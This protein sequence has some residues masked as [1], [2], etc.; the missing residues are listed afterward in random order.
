[1]AV[2]Q[3]GNKLGYN[4]GRS[5][6]FLNRPV[7]IDCSFTVADTNGLGITGLKG[8]GVQNVFM[9]TS[10]TPVVGNNG[11]L[12]PNPA[13]G[14]ALIQLANNY[15]KFAGGF[16][17]VVSPVA[18]STI[19]I[20]GSA[21]TIG[22]PYIITSVGAGTA[23]AQTIA[24]VADSS[25]NLASTWFSIYDAFGNIFIIWFSVAGVG[26]A[27]RNVAGT[28]VQQSI[29]A[30]ASAATIGAALV[31]TLN[32][33]SAQT[34]LN[35]NA[36][37]IAPFSAAGTSTV[38]VTNVVSQPFV[39]GAAD[40]SAATGFAF[41][42][43]KYKSNQQNW[44]NVGLPKG[45]I[46]AVNQSFVAIATGDST[47][48]G[49]TGLVK[50]PGVS[51]IS[52]IEIVGDPSL[53]L[54]PIPMGG[55]PNVGGWLLVQFLAPTINTGAYVAPML[56]TAPAAGSVVSLSFNVEAGSILIAGQ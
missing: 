26:S 43:T 10:T 32:A 14:F 49:S 41:A 56:P 45:L 24:P 30:N 46:P 47:G 55:S 38:T 12:N 44:N 34:L 39:G 35:P 28:L 37:N 50:V 17:G 53:N 8:S 27:P 1:M 52:S 16:M 11:I 21:L 54:A 7:K 6:S 42:V 5:Y 9:H 40:G 13:A 3:S 15:N 22:Q 25:G 2:T 20:N 48:G 23:G 29:S 18:G 31:V 51:A 19:A 33:L 36:P 4:G